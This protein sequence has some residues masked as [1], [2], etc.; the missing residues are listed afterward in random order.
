MTL[1]LDEHYADKLELEREAAS[2]IFP[3]APVR[4]L[5]RDSCH[6]LVG[7]VSMGHG[8]GCGDADG[9]SLRPSWPSQSHVTAA[10]PAHGGRVRLGVSTNFNVTFQVQ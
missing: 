7:K 1:G 6:F 8:R 5:A 10:C 9:R 2:S 4:V 3:F